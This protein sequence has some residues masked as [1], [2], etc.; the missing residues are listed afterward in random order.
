VLRILH[1][2]FRVDLWEVTVGVLITGA[3]EGT[4]FDYS[5][6]AVTT[7]TRIGSGNGS[8]GIPISL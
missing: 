2:V 1:L 8:L 7:G 5:G 6:S 3:V 4:R